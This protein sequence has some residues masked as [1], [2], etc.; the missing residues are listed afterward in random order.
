MHV[1]KYVQQRCAKSRQ[2]KKLRCKERNEERNVPLRTSSAVYLDDVSL[3]GMD[4]ADHL[5]NLDLVLARL[6]E[7]E[8]C[9]KLSKCTFLQEEVEYLGHRVG[10]AVV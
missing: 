4:E 2:Q 1:A 10:A 7:A 9:L 6:D 8:L 5:R 3:S